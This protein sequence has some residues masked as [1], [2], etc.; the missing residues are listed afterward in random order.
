MKDL[1]IFTSQLHGKA[2]ENKSKKKGKENLSLGHVLE[3]YS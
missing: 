1:A 3:T 2:V